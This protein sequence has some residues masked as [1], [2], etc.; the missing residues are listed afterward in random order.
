[1]NII[2]W[3]VVHVKLWPKMYLDHDFG[4]IFD[5]RAIEQTYEN[6]DIE[7]PDWGARSPAAA[8]SGA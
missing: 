3:D 4:G 6:H 5:F 8:G 1:M 7:V 2:S